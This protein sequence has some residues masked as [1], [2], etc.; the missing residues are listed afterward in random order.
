MIKKDKP[1]NSNEN[2]L[3]D[4]DQRIYRNYSYKTINCL[5]DRHH[6]WYTG[7]LSSKM[8]VYLVLFF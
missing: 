8:D 5:V 4:D 3:N 7:K 1:E 2:S 6:G